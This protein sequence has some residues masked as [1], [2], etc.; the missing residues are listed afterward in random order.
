MLRTTPRPIAALLLML[1][2]L[3]PTSAAL[4]APALAG[5]TKTLCVFDPSGANGYV[6]QLMKDF[7]LDAAA[8]GV[9]FDLKPYTDESTA[10]RDF[11]A[12]QCDA[13]L[14]TGTRMRPFQP[15]TSTMEALGGLPDYAITEK[16][17]KSLAKPRAGKLMRHGEYE[18]AAVFP[19]GSVFL[20]VSDRS[21][22]TVSELAGKK[23]ATLTH[24]DAAMTM[25]KR[26]GASVTGADI[27]S[28][29]SMFN[30]GSVDACYAPAYAYKALELHKGIGESGGLIHYPIAQLTM[31]MVIRSARFPSGF[32]DASRALAVK[33]FD[34]ALGL[35]RKSEA[36]IPKAAWI[37][38]PEAD[39]A[40]YDG[41]LR[42]V[43]ISLKP[44]PYDTTMLALLKKARCKS[45]PT[46]AECVL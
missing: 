19:G 41:L 36:E 20:F 27:G 16:I 43:R 26:I 33:Y 8:L 11:Q 23:V 28:F 9:R 34:K 31:Q 30:N 13:A 25:V 22:D 2:A 7:A 4:A 6:F 42:E 44:A 1:S 3:L 21:I 40:E 37:T 39:K 15:F 17:I 32:G 38:I 10:A 14:L 18:T 35:S 5:D 12:G 46:R 29:A 45:D 24:D